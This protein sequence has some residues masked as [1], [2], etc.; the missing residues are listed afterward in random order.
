MRMAGRSTYR[1]PS[2]TANHSP[3]EV[4]RALRPAPVAWRM[5]ARRVR[6]ISRS[7]IKALAARWVRV[8][9]ERAV[10][11]RHAMAHRTEEV[12]VV[13]AT[14]NALPEFSWA[15]FP[16]GAEDRTAPG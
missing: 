7:Q 13:G 6:A 11:E 2:G 9:Y 5:T 8:F 16:S 15:G 14:S 1:P 3:S 4:L 12:R 10:L